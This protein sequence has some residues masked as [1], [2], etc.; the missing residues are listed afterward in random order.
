MEKEHTCCKTKGKR[1]V[2]WGHER[3]RGDQNS[4]KK[5]HAREI[6]P[7]SAILKNKK[8]RVFD[9]ETFELRVKNFGNVANFVLRQPLRNEDGSDATLCVS[10]ATFPET[11]W[12]ARV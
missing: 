1:L 4:K 2:K 5:G 8:T 10:T 6:P 12:R 11:R 3:M 7:S 9:L